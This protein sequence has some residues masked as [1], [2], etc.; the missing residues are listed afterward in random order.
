M[1]GELFISREEEQEET[2]EPENSEDDIED[3]PV[4]L[5][6]EEKMIGGYVLDEKLG[7]GNSATVW[8]AYKKENPGQKIALKQANSVLKED[9][10]QFNREAAA[11]LKI[12]EGISHPNLVKVLDIGIC[13]DKPYIAMEHVDG[14]DL[15]TVLQGYQNIQSG[16]EKQFMPIEKAF[17]ILLQVAKA[18]QVSHENGVIHRDIKPRNILISRYD[19]VKIAD[20]GLSKVQSDDL[21]HSLSFSSENPEIVGTVEYMSPNQKKG[22]KAQPQDDFYSFGVVLYKM[23]TNSFPSDNHFNDLPSAIN[24]S[25]SGHVDKIFNKCLGLNSEVYYASSEELIKDV[26]WVKDNFE[27]MDSS[28]IPCLTQNTEANIR[29]YCLGQGGVHEMFLRLHKEL[30]AIGEYEQLFY[31]SDDKLKVNSKK[32]SRA[33][34]LKVSEKYLHIQVLEKRSFYRTFFGDN[35]ETAELCNW[36]KI[37]FAKEPVYDV[38]EEK[39]Q[40]KWFGKNSLFGFPLGEKIITHKTKIGEE[41]SFTYA[42]IVK[43]NGFTPE[44]TEISGNPELFF[45]YF[46]KRFYHKQGEVLQV[47]RVLHE[48]PDLIRTYFAGLNERSKNIG[49]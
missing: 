37:K 34:E 30:Q 41:D 21:K 25:L 12:N 10:E 13:E 2:V 47:M 43:K 44:H 23:L 45:N 29:D 27:V 1:G 22:G 5:V 17:D 35:A 15:E 18:I 9:V 24:D 46:I 14:N 4:A 32:A 16:S 8:S 33:I 19:T 40:R 26:G 28:S 31:W 3:K 7:E 48:I 11:L 36:L 49:S 38:E 6:S 20:F 39:V 42:W